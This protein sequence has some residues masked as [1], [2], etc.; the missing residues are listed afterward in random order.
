MKTLTQF[1]R[2]T[3]LLLW[4]VMLISPGLFAGT[5]LNLKTSVPESGSIFTADQTMED[6]I[7]TE[8]PYTQNFDDSN[9][10]PPGWI[11]KT[12]SNSS[13][14]IKI[15][16]RQYSSAPN[17]LVL[18]NFSANIN[19]VVTLPKFAIPI[20]E[21]EI[22]FS[23][24]PI[25][26]LTIAATKLQVGILTNPEDTSTFVPVRT[27]T[28]TAQSRT[29]H[30]VTFENYIGEGEYIAIRWSSVGIYAL[31][32]DDVTV[33]STSGCLAPGEIRIDEV[34]G[35][36][37]SIS[38]EP[39]TSSVQD[40][41]VE[42]TI[43]GT[44]NWTP[45]Y[46]EE[47]SAVLSGLS[48]KTYYDVKVSAICNEGESNPVTS[49]FFTICNNLTDQQIGN[50]NTL[51]SDFPLYSSL[52]YSYSQQ[53]FTAEEF[54]GNMEIELVAFQFNNNNGLE[55]NRALNIY[56]GNSDTLPVSTWIPKGDLQHVYAGTVNFHNRDENGWV[57][58]LLDQPFSYEA[59]KNL[60]IVVYDTTGNS[61][62]QSNFYSHTSTIPSLRIAQNGRISIEGPAETSQM[63]MTRNNVRFSSCAEI[64]CN[65]PGYLRASNITGEDAYITW[66]EEGIAGSYQ[67]EY[68]SGE[69][70]T[71]TFYEETNNLFTTFS[72]L[73][74]QTSYKIRVRGICSETDTSEWSEISFTT[75]CRT[76]EL[77]LV[78][79]FDHTT[80]QTLPE[81]WQGFTT[82]ASN[83][84]F[85]ERPSGDNSISSPGILNFNTT[86]GGYNLAILPRTELQGQYDDLWITF[87]AK[88]TPGNTGT[89]SLGIMDDPNIPSTFTF[90]AEVNFTDDSLWNE[91]DLVVPDYHGTGNYI[92]FR[93]YNA[94][95]F[96]M[97][98]LVIETTPSCYKPTE[99]YVDDITPTS[100]RINWTDNNGEIEWIIRHRAV[101][102]GGEFT[103][104]TVDVNPYIL[105]GLVPNQSY[106]FYISSLC[107][108]E[109]TSRLSHRLIFT[110]E[111]R[112]L[113]RD[114]IPYYQNFDDIQDL[115]ALPACWT[116]LT[117]NTGFSIEYPRLENAYTYSPYRSL[118][119]RSEPG[120]Y[121]MI[122]MEEFDESIRID[123][124][125][126]SFMRYPRNGSTILVG[127]MTDPT[128]ESTFTQLNSV[129]AIGTGWNS[130][131]LSLSG[132]QNGQGR[133]I[134][135][136]T[137]GPEDYVAIDDI[138]I[139][140]AS[141]CEVPTN[142]RAHDISFVEASVSWTPQGTETS[143]VLQ[144]RENGPL[145][146]QSIV[147]PNTPTYHFNNLEAGLNYEFRVRAICSEGDSSSFSQITRF[148]T[149][150]EAPTTFETTDI[151]DHE[152]FV[153]WSRNYPSE[154]WLIGVKRSGP[155][156][157]YAYS[158]TI[159]DRTTFS[160]D[161]LVP[162]L[163]YE[164]TIFTLCNRHGGTSEKTLQFTT[165]TTPRPEY[166]TIR[167]TSGPHGRIVPSGDI[168]VPYGTDTTFKF[169][170]DEGYLI[171]S[172]IVDNQSQAV[173]TFYTFRNVT[174]DH[175]I[176]VDFL[177]TGITEND[178]DNRIRIYP[179]PVSQTLFI[180][181]DI[182]FEYIKIT[183]LPGQILYNNTVSGNKTELD[184]ALYPP[185]IYFIT[186]EGKNGYVTKKFI[187]K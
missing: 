123:S 29:N 65:A 54:S 64:G 184:V 51:T 180:E 46:T 115:S 109:D 7:I 149:L 20:Q 101:N 83:T 6:V 107:G 174:S 133:Y 181:H 170:P 116:R 57:Y 58:I 39:S 134:A 130:E 103:S 11:A 19:S 74:P 129:T 28:T 4:T 145:N 75:L 105:T 13:E 32:I 81:C 155:S 162:G 135:I 35:T 173:D 86:T 131:E 110:T 71:W 140:I 2:I 150:C 24:I 113:G 137:G 12:N 50:G 18:N 139:D 163:N 148:T 96:Y 93:S 43:H 104:D 128:D 47:T 8:L 158:D 146:W 186:L 37:A 111:C 167:A 60:I 70:E 72:T 112:A 77:P 92:A 164:I 166:L 165:E 97:D 126:I 16:N 172:V 66:V 118:M 53:I 121:S 147:V 183:T 30:I 156:M 136:K 76:F 95:P 78:E 22:S 178:M 89:L 127:V 49:T 87:W 100:A 31:Y 169:R 14:K 84:P 73:T 15:V 59:E 177:T 175:M 10:L 42:Y 122:V 106:E 185:G 94:L 141:D 187:K 142:L 154:R 152:V 160:V 44:E 69:D 91:Y 132:Y 63:M 48:E 61:S 138:R 41:V 90:V 124:L 55:L 99:I 62:G 114:A 153:S 40:Y 36:S 102:N 27:L 179:N 108:E 161:T 120:H 82:L 52:G 9:Q 159:S 176:S 143:W 68:Q 171:R 45:I 88:S 182:P 151:T 117:D 5:P 125:T 17:S 1:Q 34:S 25:P 23:A 168:R 119:F 3:A 38:W 56:L 79:Y 67:V 144:I 80:P 26:G 21:L 157:P 85:V 33:Q 98:N